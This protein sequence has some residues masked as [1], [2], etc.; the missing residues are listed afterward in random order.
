MPHFN[1]ILNMLFARK[2][3]KPP[4]FQTC[5][6]FNIQFL[7]FVQLTHPRENV[8]RCGTYRGC[9]ESAELDA[10]ARTHSHMTHLIENQA[11]CQR[12]PFTLHPGW[13]AQ[14][15]SQFGAPHLCE[16]GYISPFSI[17]SLSTYIL[18]SSSKVK[19]GGISPTGNLH[20]CTGPPLKTE[21]R[22]S[23]SFLHGIF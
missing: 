5:L 7:T 18:V 21:G 1:P 4:Q 17:F 20:S 8:S 11:I 14:T 16:G 6:D 12:R 23:F 22:K 10:R 13:N 2:A 15:Q 3:I 19:E 9:S